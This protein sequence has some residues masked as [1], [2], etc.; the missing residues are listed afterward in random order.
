MLLR[1]VGPPPSIR[2]VPR[3]RHESQAYR[4]WGPLQVVLLTPYAPVLGAMIFS[5]WPVG[6]LLQAQRCVL[7]NRPL[8]KFFGS[9]YYCINTTTIYRQYGL[10]L[11][12][13][14]T[15]QRQNSVSAFSRFH[16]NDSPVSHAQTWTAIDDH[17]ELE[18]QR[19]ERRKST[20]LPWAQL[21]VLFWMRLIEPIC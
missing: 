8:K 11:R 7:A 10:H 2:G 20:P 9:N 6:S 3:K 16:P 15:C 4:V 13:R 21:S 19:A 1:G 18:A 5:M 14:A 17:V 12:S